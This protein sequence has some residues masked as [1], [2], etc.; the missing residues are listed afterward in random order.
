MKMKAADRKKANDL[1]KA[2]MDNLEEERR[3]RREMAAKVCD[4]M[5]K[6][7]IIYK[8]YRALVPDD[9]AL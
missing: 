2:Y 3:I 9:N 5:R 4:L 6:R 8:E 1:L 7:E